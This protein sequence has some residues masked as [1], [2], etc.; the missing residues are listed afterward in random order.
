M[1]HSPEKRTN[2]MRPGA[3]RQPSPACA[4][5]TASHSAIGTWSAVRIS[6]APP[7]RN[8]NALANTAP[9]ANSIA[10]VRA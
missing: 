3:V 4:R 9:A 7:G 2:P 1:N 5:P 8:G 6:V 10:T